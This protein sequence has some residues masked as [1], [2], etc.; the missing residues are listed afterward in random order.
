MQ[1]A[2]AGGVG[3]EWDISYAYYDPGNTVWSITNP[4][5]RSSELI[6][7]QTTTPSGL[8]F[9]PDGTKMYVSDHERVIEY[10]VGNT[11]TISTASVS[12]AYYFYNYTTSSYTGVAFKSD[13]TKMY[14]TNFTDKQVEEYTLSTAWDISTASYVQAK[15]V[16]TKES[17]PQDLFLKPDGT[18]LYII[19]SGGIEVN[20]YSLST[21]W[22]IS[23]MSHV[24]E[25]SVSAEGTFPNGLFF[26]DDGTKMF[27]TDSQVD[28]VNEYSLST[29]W[30]ISTASFTQFF[31]VDAAVTEP[32]PTSLYIKPDGATLYVLGDST[33][34]VYQFSLGGFNVS[35]EELSPYGIFFKDDGTRMYIIGGHGDEVNEYTLSTEWDISTASAVRVFSVQ[36]QETTAQDLFFKPDGTKMYIIGTSSD[37]VSEYDLSTAWNISTASYLQTISVGSWESNARGLFFKDDGT[38]MFITGSGGD[39]VNEFSLSTAWDISTKSF[40][41]V[42]SVAAQE[43]V[44][45]TISFGDNGRKMYILGQ[46]GDD[47]NQYNLSTAWDISTASYVQTFLVKNE[48]D[49]PNG[50]F[51]K[52]DGTQFWVVGTETDSVWSYTIDNQ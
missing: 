33:D 36:T 12:Q 42:F 37:A 1:Q 18:K 19:G 51:F 10:N 29:A 23:T 8:F 27:T 22:D 34:T 15:S 35:S 20:E 5:Q 14:A 21:A 24:Q 46:L 25:K 45:N 30:D 48:E 2:A 26:K 28:Y 40:T 31:D 47:I 41:R 13:G 52:P 44:P 3:V 39:E 16:S 17:A 4:I 6:S 11:A 43:T 7:L 50:L 9:K 38:K 49:T 32:S